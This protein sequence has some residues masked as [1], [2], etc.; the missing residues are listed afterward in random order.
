[1]ARE[2]LNKG[3]LNR[4]RRQQ[5][6]YERVLPSLDLKRRQLIVERQRAEREL[7]QLDD[8][9][10]RLTTE[11]SEQLPMLAVRG[12][13]LKGL[14]HVERAQVTYRNLLG[15]RLPQA[16]EF[17]ITIRPYSYLG[18]PHWVDAAAE[19][20]RELAELRLRREIAAERVRRLMAAERKAVQRVNLLDK[21]LVPRTRERIRRVEIAL[22]DAERTAVVRSK[23][24]KRRH[25]RS[26]ATA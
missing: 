4:L 20:V 14:A 8:D 9:I 2:A 18:K 13:P 10:E 6:L 11:T 16:G 26:E 19:R 23:I 7:Q 24:A 25:K 1:M 17:E 3:T 15:V 22:A 21:V 5:A 12:I